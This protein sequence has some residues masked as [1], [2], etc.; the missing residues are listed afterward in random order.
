MFYRPQEILNRI[1][2]FPIKCRIQNAK[3][4][5]RKYQTDLRLDEQ[6]WTSSSGEAFRP[7]MKV[8][9]DS[10]QAWAIVT[11]NALHGT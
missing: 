1:E 6:F 2:F 8:Q 4:N 9:H 7:K 10:T 3:D 11:S 5:F